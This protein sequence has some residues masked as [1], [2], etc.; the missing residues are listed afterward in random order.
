MSAP[1]TTASQTEFCN[2]MSHVNIASEPASGYDTPIPN[3]RISEETL[4]TLNE[5]KA[6]LGQSLSKK[7][8][9][10]KRKRL[11]SP[12]R[13][14]PPNKEKYV[15]A[16]DQYPSQAKPIYLK[17]KGLHKKKLSLASLIKVMEGKLSKNQYPSSVD[18]K[19]N[20]NSNRNP[21]LKDAWSRTIRKCKTD[22][23]LALIE[24]LQSTYSRTKA[25]IAK[26]LA[27]LETLLNQQQFQEIK[28][29]LTNKFKQMAPT[30]MERKQNQFRVQRETKPARRRTN[31]GPRNPRQ[32]KKQRVDP[33]LDNLITTLRTL[34]KQ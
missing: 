2:A 33:K 9:P 32:N 7:D 29:S 12:D 23:T 17:L 4:K 3:N 28:D 30:L 11:D 22:L 14:E 26:E 6:K 1:S 20:I 8:N 13:G 34:L 25:A 5:V 24:D 19:F 31:Q 18:F 15:D 10:N 21:V 16:R 27:E